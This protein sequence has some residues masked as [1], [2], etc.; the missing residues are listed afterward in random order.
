MSDFLSSFTPGKYDGT[1]KM[2]PEKRSTEAEKKETAAPAAAQ[3]FETAPKPAAET[4]Y[5]QTVPE[6]DNVRYELFEKDPGSGK[7]R[8]RRIIFSVLAVIVVL[9]L[10]GLLYYS[11]QV[12]KL[13]NLVGDYADKAEVWALQNNI[14]LELKEEFN[15]EFGRG[16][17]I[18][19]EPAPGEKLFKGDSVMMTVSRGLN[20]DEHIAL[21][22]FSQMELSEIQEWIEENKA[23]NV[24]INW[25][26]SDE[27]PSNR[28]IRKEFRSN[29]V[30]EENYK[31]KDRMIIV[32]SRGQQEI[33][34]DIE[35]PNFREKPEMDATHWAETQDIELQVRK[36]YSDTVPKGYII[37]QSI[38]PKTMIDN[39]EELTITVSKGKAVYAPSLAGLS[40]EEAQQRAQD[41]GIMLMIIRQYHNDVEI[42]GLISQSVPAGTLLE[43]D[44][45]SMIA[46]YSLG[47]PYIPDL[48]G[49][50]ENDVIQLVATMNNQK[51][52]LT[53]EYKYVNDDFIPKGTVV[54]NTHANKVVPVGST[55]TVTVSRGSRVTIGDY[56]GKDYYSDEV[57]EE[58]QKLKDLG[59]KINIRTVP[60]FYESGTVV[61]QSIPAGTQVNAADHLLVITLAE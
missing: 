37:S 17:V 25:E 31:R 7:R 56:V 14:F 15:T 8:A 16:I 3:G 23:E 60:S 26:Y 10:G 59:L 6:F 35:V 27:V 36:E 32:M 4:A 54:F 22:D 40:E 2:P 49:K 52:D 34:K 9:L 43:E 33:E 29:A 13:P 50:S 39:N 11:S 42:G 47:R 38:P 24:T 28:F 48:S 53:C 20:P 55:F 12:V 46:Y 5:R 58:I 30:T 45:N 1:G 19:Q 57:T 51:A 18:H 41:A 44:H 21:P 61:S